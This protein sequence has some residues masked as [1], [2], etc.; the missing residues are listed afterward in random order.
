MNRQQNGRRAPAPRQRKD[1][2]YVRGLLEEDDH[3]RRDLRKITHRHAQQV[4][5]LTVR[6]AKLER[7][8]RSLRVELTHH[9]RGR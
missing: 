1:M 4:Q 8:N 3:L 5:Q 6:I 7:E 2:H 9:E